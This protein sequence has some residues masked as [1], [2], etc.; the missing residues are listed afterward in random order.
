MKRIMLLLCLLAAS[1]SPAQL[2]PLSLVNPL[3]GTDSSGQFSHGNTVPEVALPWP[4]NAWSAYTRPQ[5][6]TFYYR[7]H[8]EKIR[9]LRQTHQPSP[10]MGDYANFALMP[11]SGKLVLDEEGRASSF[12]HENEISQPSYYKVRLDTWKVTAEMTPTDR[13]ARFRF[14]FEEPGDAFVVLDVFQSD[15][16][17]SAQIIPAENKIIGI[18]S[19]NRGGVPVNFANYFVIIFDQPFAAWGVTASNAPMMSVRD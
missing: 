14:H 18:D 2:T 6:D 3:M 8:D 19:N 11:V 9:G 10:W 12:S 5:S 16:N 1:P 13:A 7:Y 4:V 17:C 15:R